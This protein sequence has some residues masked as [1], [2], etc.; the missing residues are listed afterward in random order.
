MRGDAPFDVLSYRYADEN[1]DVFNLNRAESGIG[2]IQ[3]S[4]Q[5]FLGCFATADSTALEPVA[6][7]GIKLPTG[8]SSELRGSGELD[9]YVDFQ[10]PVYTNGGRW[11]GGVAIGALYAGQSSLF[12]NQHSIVGYGSIGTQFVFNSR[13][14]FLMQLDWN[15]PFFKSDLR[16]LGNL[17]IGV[18][19]GVRVIGPSDQSFEFSI[20]EDAA[21][22]TTPDIVARFSWSYRPS[23]GR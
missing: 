4:L 5:R 7:V 6:R 2:D 12:L 3:I 1:G 17:A 21:I 9:A 20:S 18:T 13:V 8:S 10:S 11:R 22:D 16:E 19:A 15:T 23:G 14:R